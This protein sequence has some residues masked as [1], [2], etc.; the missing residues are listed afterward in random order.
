MITEVTAQV[1]FTGT[2][3]ALYRLYDAQG[4]LL[5]VGITCN[6]KRRMGQHSVRPWWPLVTRKTMTWYGTERDAR[7]AEAVAIG[8]ENPLY[9][10]ARPLTEDVT[11]RHGKRSGWNRNRFPLLAWHPPAELSAWVR[12]EAKRRGVP[13]SVILTEALETYRLA[14]AVQSPP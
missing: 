4:V 7:A 10:M 11:P 8:D 6:L 2:P 13:L 14:R 5:Y 12:A 1:E 3:T 9:N